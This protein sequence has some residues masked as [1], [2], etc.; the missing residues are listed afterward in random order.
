MNS[1][2]P[3][4]L[5]RFSWDAPQSYKALYLNLW[6]NSDER[7]VSSFD[8]LVEFFTPDGRWLTS[9][10]EPDAMDVNIEAKENASDDDSD[11]KDDVDDQVEVDGEGEGKGEG[12]GEGAADDPNNLGPP[13]IR[14]INLNA[15]PYLFIPQLIDMA[16][17]HGEKAAL[18]VR[19]EYEIFFDHARS[20]I[21]NPDNKTSNFFLTGQPGIGKS[22]C[23]YYIL[24]RLLASG[25]SVFFLR[26]STETLYFS[27]DGVQEQVGLCVS[28]NDESLQAIAASWVLIDVENEA[29]FRCLDRL[30]NALCVVWTSSPRKTRRNHFTKRFSAD[31]WFMRCWWSAEIAALT[32]L[33][34][35]DRSKILRKFNIVGPIPRSLFGKAPFPAKMKLVQDIRS[36]IGNDIFLFNP[37]DENAH[38][39]PSHRVMRVDPMIVVNTRGQARLQRNC[40]S[41][42][43]LS[44]HIWDLALDELQRRFE[45]LQEQ[46][47]IILDTSTTHSLAGRVVEGLMHRSLEQ[48]TK[49]PA[50][51][52]ACTI[53]K[54]VTL[55]GKAESFSSEG[56]TGAYPLYLRPKSSTFATVDAMVVLVTTLVLI[57][58][59]LSTSHQRNF[60]IMLKIISRMLDG[61]RVRVGSSWEIVYCIIGTVNKSVDELV[62][63]TS[64]TLA[65][66]QK[67]DT[68]EL[69]KQLDVNP[70]T[71]IAR[72][73]IRNMRVYVLHRHGL[74]MHR[75]LPSL[76][77]LQPETRRERASLV[78]GA[79]PR[80]SRFRGK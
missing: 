25:Q 47:A 33:L 46:L 71:E 63:Q 29:N 31:S 59:S 30:K 22:M 43:F 52:G 42:Q 53:A 6:P 32:K 57:Q 15:H 48:G 9:Q 69:C 34:D 20:R 26:S 77:L 56:A 58:T 79:A 80:H 19:H 67:L 49:L 11:S 37:E 5:P 76:R 55:F 40:Y 21:G 54:M 61:V 72:T 64:R 24:F 60:C 62:A 36:A 12:D 10:V 28:E 14:F 8:D 16:K 51:F 74:E 45:Q 65:E 35:M 23:C 17:E 50:E 78:I 66:L 39:E 1:R 70:P 27:S 75:I 4:L 73:R 7:S 18:L 2:N 44:S 13:T 68:V 38:S 41:K 3:Q